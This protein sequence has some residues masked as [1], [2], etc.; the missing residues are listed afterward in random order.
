[1][2]KHIYATIAFFFF[3][4]MAMAQQPQ[5]LTPAEAEVYKQHKSEVLAFTNIA[6]D[7]KLAEMYVKHFMTAECRLSVKPI[8]EEREMRMSIC[9]FIYPDDENARYKAKQEIL[10]NYVIPITRVLL[11]GGTKATTENYSLLLIKRKALS[12]SQAQFD[13]IVEK[14]IELN[15]LM[16]TNPKTD[17]WGHE[18]ATFNSVLNTGQV[19]IFFKMKN[20]RKVGED[21]QKCWS[22]LKENKMTNDLDSANEFSKM[23]KY[24]HLIYKA[25]AINYKNAELRGQAFK[26]IKQNAPLSVRRLKNCPT[27]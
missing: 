7:E 10:S 19:D 8:V 17:T 11:Q 27:N 16:K 22:T 3:C 14:A 18:L 2:R 12:L 4:F 20:S 24:Y 23:Y 26:T 21:M 13:Q 5:Y 25:S 15:Q 9:N 1:M 6:V